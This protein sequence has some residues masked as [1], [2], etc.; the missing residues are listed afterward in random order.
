MDALAFLAKNTKRQPI[1]VLNGDE[2]FLVRRCRDAIVRRVVGDADPE[3]AVA[4]YPGASTEF[5]TI[6]NE[7]DTLPFLAPARIVVIEQ[8]DEF[9]SNHRESLEKYAAKPSKIGVL[10]LELKTFPETTRLAKALTDGMKLACKAPK[11]YTLPDWCSSWAQSAHGKKLGKGAAAMLFERVGAQMGLLAAEIDKLATAIGDK[12]EI[13]AADVDRLISRSREGNVFR[14]LDAIGEGKPGEA[15]SVLAEIFDDG[16][17]PLAVLGALTFQLRRLASFERY[18]KLGM[19]PYHA[20]DAAGVAKWD[21]ARDAFKKLSQHLG[22][23]RLALLTE[24][25]VEVN[26]GMKGG[27]PLPPQLQ[28][29]RLVVK[30]AK[31]RA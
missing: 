7:L 27:N 2:N 13:E 6:R 18:M 4:I 31:P 24:W 3:Y 16:D 19:D 12:S 8:A 5:S 20:M 10:V 11:A 28:V 23:S 30:L 25:I 29:E 26:Q 15:L 9:V 1:Y 21:A 22:R 17:N 14:I